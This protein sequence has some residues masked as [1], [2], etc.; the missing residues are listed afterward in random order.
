MRASPIRW[1]RKP[2]TR[3]ARPVC[4]Y[5]PSMGDPNI[6][7]V[8]RYALG[9]Q[10]AQQYGSPGFQGGLLNNYGAGLGY[11]NTG[12]MPNKTVGGL[13]GQPLPNPDNVPTP[14]QTLGAATGNQYAPMRQPG[15]G[16]APTTQ[17]GY[18][19]QMQQ[20]NPGGLF[21][22]G[23]LP[24]MGTSAGGATRPMWMGAPAQPQASSGFPSYADWNR[25]RGGPSQRPITRDRQAADAAGHAN[26][27]QGWN[28]QL[29][30]R[31]LGVQQNAIN[32]TDARRVRM[33]IGDPVDMAMRQN[34]EI[35]GMMGMG[36]MG[37][38]GQ[39]MQYGLMGQAMQQQAHQQ[40]LQNLTGLAG[41]I[42]QM[43]IPPGLKQQYMGQ[44]MQAHG[45]QMPAGGGQQAP[46]GLF[47][48]NRT[49]YFVPHQVQAQ[50]MQAKTQ[51]EK[52]A[53]LNQNGITDIATRHQLLGWAK[54]SADAWNSR[55]LRRLRAESRK[56]CLRSASVGTAS[57]DATDADS[58]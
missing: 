50:L 5:Q 58:G 13:F 33:G 47:G 57:A 17:Q 16:M 8:G 37:L 51:Q 11:G 3:V 52:E 55:W 14:Q 35:A 41:A 18:Q 19:Q 22:G 15:L 26:Y 6:S 53:I 10:H 43:D 56:Q 42:G 48:Q 23:A 49:N 46:G 32:K 25:A 24:A 36:R 54:Y 29:G 34:P 9:L 39:M 2:G 7:G 28:Q 12:Y 40:H 44:I 20:Q 1:P 4:A 31:G 45:L 27:M 21:F 38:Q 30:L